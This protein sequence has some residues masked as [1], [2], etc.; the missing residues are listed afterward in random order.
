MYKHGFVMLVI[1]L[2]AGCA[3]TSD[4]MMRFGDT[5]RAY[6]RALRW[7]EYDT[8]YSVHKNEKGSLPDSERKR[9]AN[10]RVTVYKLVN[11]KSENDNKRIVQQLEISYYNKEYLVVKTMPLTLEWEQDAKT[12]SWAIVSP[13]PKFK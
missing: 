7:G 5:T 13:F 3:T 10:I 1:M 11:S 12:G 2:L 6:E 4:D 9:L 8:V